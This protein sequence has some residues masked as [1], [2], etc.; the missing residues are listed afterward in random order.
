MLKDNI[1]QNRFN[2]ILERR[3]VE[4]QEFLSGHSLMNLTVE[5]KFDRVLGGLLMKIKTEILAETEP[6]E[7]Y[8]AVFK[9]HKSWWQWFKD[10]NLPKWFKKIYPIKYISVKKYLTIYRE[11]WYPKLNKVFP[12]SGTPIIKEFIEEKE[13]RNY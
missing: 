13:I 12:E 7:L 5:Q 1:A 6:K 4:A 9:M 11:A 3:K 2:D 8:V 10:E